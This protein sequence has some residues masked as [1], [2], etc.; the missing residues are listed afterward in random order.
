MDLLL[1]SLIA[2]VYYQY[3]VRHA[4]QCSSSFYKYDRIIQNLIHRGRKKN[5]EPREQDFLRQV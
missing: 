3:N 5:A 1:F 4:T 2:P